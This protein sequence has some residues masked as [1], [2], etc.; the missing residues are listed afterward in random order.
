ML[1]PCAIGCG[2]PAE[3]EGTGGGSARGVEHGLPRLEDGP[4]TQRAR[5]E[6]ALLAD[7]TGTT[8]HEGFRGLRRIGRDAVPAIVEALYG[9]YTEEV[10]QNAVAILGEIGLA[11]AE[12]RPFLEDIRISGNTH[13]SYAADLALRKIEQAE[14]CGLPGLPDD[15][16]I[17]IVGRYR[18]EK[19][20]DVQLGQSGHTVTEI[21]VV[22]DHT[23][24]P[25]ALV[26]IAYDPVVWRVGRTPDS[27]LAAVLVSGYHTPALIGIPRTLEHKVISGEESMGCEALKGSSPGDAPTLDR[28][29]VRLTGHHIDRF[30]SASPAAHFSVGGRPG[31]KPSNIEY[32]DDLS[33]ADYNVYQGDIPAGPRGIEELHRR[34]MIRLATQED[35]DAWMAGAKKHHPD[36]YARLYTGSTYV[37]LEPITLP[38]GLFGA[39]AQAFIIPAAQARPDGPKG[40][41]QFY[42]MKDFTWE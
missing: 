40:H 9:S 35:I 30:H 4:L 10:K 26:L 8:V 11:A 39:H 1:L 20:L 25:V 16:E 31:F 27:K 42:Y 12:A 6:L 13:L 21:E 38:P 17:H 2:G 22:V 37:V 15:V 29:I 24:R 7:S 23:E 33:L 41:C 14:A 19:E 5:A 28:D 18:G 34:G 36:Q 32:S 3:R